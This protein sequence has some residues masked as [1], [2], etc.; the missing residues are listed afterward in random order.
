[1]THYL[2]IAVRAFTDARKPRG[3]RRTNRTAKKVQDWRLPARVL[4]LDC[5]TETA[6]H[7]Q[8]LSFGSY[9]YCAIDKTGHLEVLEEGLYHADELASRDPTGHA[10]LETYARNNGLPLLSRSGFV[11]QV[12]WRSAYKVRAWVVGFNLP[13]DLSRLAVA[14]GEARG[15]YAGGHSLVL[16]QYQDE[17]GA[18]QEDRYRP[19]VLIKS[20]DSK[21][22][23]IGLSQRRDPD[24]DDLIAEER[25]DGQAEPGYRFRGHFLDLRTLAFALTNRSRSLA[26][27]CRA[28]KVEQQK[29]EAMQHGVITSAYIDYNRQDVRATGSLLEALLAEYRQHPVALP[30]TK[31]Y[32]PAAIAKAYLKAMGVRKPLERQPNFPREVLGAAM[33]AY[34][35]GRTECRIRCRAVPVVYV[36]FLSMYP[37]VNTLMGLWRY[38]IAQ[39]ITTVDNTEE[40][41]EL[42]EQVT[43][44]QCFTPGFWPQL[45]ALVQV[46]PDGDVLPTRADYGENGQWQIG[47]NPLHSEVALWYPLADVIASTLITG[48]PPKIVRALRLVADGQQPGMRPVR[49]AGE[50][51]IDPIR[52]D[53]FATLIEQ[54]H[55]TTAREDLDPGERERIRA[56]LKVLANSGC[57]GIFAEINRE[58]LGTH[59]P[60]TIH[61]LHDAFTQRLSTVE[62]PGEYSFPPLAACITGAARLMLALLERVVTDAEGSY[63]FC[64]TDSMAIIATPATGLVPCSGGHH[65]T[66]DG[67]DAIRALSYEQIGEIIARFAS[68]NPYNP[69][70]VPGSILELE[71]WNFHRDTGERRQLYCYAISAKRYALY[72]LDQHGRPIPRKWSEHGLGHLLSPLDPGTEDRNLARHVWQEILDDALGLKQCSTAN[73]STGR[74]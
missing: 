30:P 65:Q 57:Y 38:V 69:E 45:L 62:S 26:T 2:P 27:A 24:A 35:G 31:A 13:F 9:R 18:W 5:E 16:S 42:V 52:D 71:E 17:D 58:E 48:R 64:D 43:I 49:L 3:K 29:Q 28:F 51:E 19:R 44:D 33:V 67:S 73:G 66:S 54:R 36:D 8:H 10:V 1:M 21:R 22:A 4:L 59:Q 12:F 47:L 20:I 46:E 7:G 32:S 63:A 34:Y 53:F 61:G 56:F 50:V 23:F 72:N 39:R 6:G 15:L 70:L 37:T 74:T 25:P 68:L 60:V 40:V 14:F 41:R 55:Q 11:E